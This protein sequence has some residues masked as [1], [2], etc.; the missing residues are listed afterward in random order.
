MV[1]QT[2]MALGMPCVRLPLCSRT[3]LCFM[4]GYR[5]HLGPVDGSGSHSIPFSLSRASP[6][7]SARPERA[8][9]GACGV[10]WRLFFDQG[11]LGSTCIVSGRI[12]ACC[13]AVSRVPFRVVD[14]ARCEPSRHAKS[15]SKMVYVAPNNIIFVLCVALS[16]SISLYIS[17]SLYLPLIFP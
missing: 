1:L 13:L 8:T 2:L 9:N 17:T 5:P 15:A 11:L 16:L 7:R 14:M 4:L 12:L 10:E 3:A 6:A